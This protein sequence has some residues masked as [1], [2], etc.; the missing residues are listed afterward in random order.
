M[1]HGL[2]VT[3][4][5]LRRNG[6]ALLRRDFL[7]VRVV[8]ATGVALVRLFQAQALFLV[9][10]DL[11]VA[12]V[13]LLQERRGA[14]DADAPGFLDPVPHGITAVVMNDAAGAVIRLAGLQRRGSRFLARR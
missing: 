3:R 8:A 1:T 13:E 5:L 12:E 10:L 2:C 9:A 6:L 14:V 7:V 11:E 4:L